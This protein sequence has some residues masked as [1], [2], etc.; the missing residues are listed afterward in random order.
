MSIIEIKNLTKKFG[1]FTAVDNV[2]LSIERGE[3]FGL[4]G[5]NGAGKT[6]LLSMLTT[7][8][9]PT[10]G[11]AYV[12]GKSILNDKH[13]VRKL[14]GMVFQNQSLDDDLSA[15]ENLDFHGEIYGLPKKLREQKIDE[16][17][18]LV[19]LGERKDDKVKKF[20][21]G[22]KR[23][24]EIVRSLMHEP[25]IVFLDEPSVGLDPQ[26]RNSLIEYIKKLNVE[27]NITVIMT[28]HYMDE[29]D[30]LC[31]RIGIIDKG[32]VI[33]MDNSD[34][35]KK[36]VGGEVINLESTD[37]EK[38]K[39]LIA[40]DKKYNVVTKEGK[41]LEISSDDAKA[42]ASHLVILAHKNN[43]KIISTQVHTPTLEDVFL[44]L[45]GK[46]IREEESHGQSIN[47]KRRMSRRRD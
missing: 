9:K 7:L 47:V 19:G 18:A 21:G 43:I 12:D 24:L 44:K 4:L 34:N 38:L 23:R 41:N 33:A 5:P 45:T 1:N 35:L 39:K 31:S 10:S 2:S 29:A 37:P 15:Y 28:T 25:K 11:E 17:L 32:K 3:I 26:T 22:M 6:T 27:K 40:K 20:S 30:K 16:L 46:T 13:E 42:N 14:I 8:L 36:L